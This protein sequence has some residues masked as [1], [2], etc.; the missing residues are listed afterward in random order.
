MTYEENDE[1]RMTF[2]KS[3]CNASTSTTAGFTT[4]N[5]SLT[6]VVFLAT[7]TT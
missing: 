3:A 7:A 1:N 5:W 4:G 6:N 2:E